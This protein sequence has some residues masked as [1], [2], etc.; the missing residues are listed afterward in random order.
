MPTVGSHHHSGI[1]Y[2]SL[3]TSPPL[4]TPSLFFT[5]SLLPST[6]PLLSRPSTMRQASW[7]V[8]C[9]ACSSWSYCPWLASSS[10]CAAAA[11]TAAA[12]CTSASGRTLTANGACSPHCSLPPR[13]SSRES[14]CVD[15]FIPCITGGSQL[16][17][18][19][20]PLY[21]RGGFT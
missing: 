20:L 5:L 16:K 8:P 3:S 15:I 14:I 4:L 10:A 2:C 7:C 18:V 12:R 11:K 17:V 13:S 1:I 6:A 21:R 9:S 19:T